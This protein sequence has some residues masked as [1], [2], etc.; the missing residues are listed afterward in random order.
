MPKGESGRIVIE[1]DP[2]LKRRLYVALA[3]DASTLKDW[4]VAAAIN[5]VAERPQPNLPN[6]TRAKRE[7]VTKQ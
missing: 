4:F 6:I 7:K 3:G 1:V 5:Y 2:D